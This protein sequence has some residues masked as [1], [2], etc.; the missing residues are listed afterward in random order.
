MTNKF[1][2]HWQVVRLEAKGLRSVSHKIELVLSWLRSN[3][4]QHNYER[5]MN[6]LRTSGYAYSN[7]E[8]QEFERA[9]LY[10]LRNKPRFCM[11][12]EDMDDDFNAYSKGVLEA[13]L[14]DLENRKYAFQYGGQAP[15]SHNEFVDKL[16]DA[17]QQRG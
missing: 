10:L 16:R 4:N 14:K 2:I 5:V 13:L 9:R 7:L 8:K 3:S 17:L 11:D 15:V 6:W 12:K 1:N